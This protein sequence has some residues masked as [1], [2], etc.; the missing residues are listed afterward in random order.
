[1]M[2]SQDGRLWSSP[3]PVFGSGSGGWYPSLAWDPTYHEPAIAFYYCD[4]RVGQ[5]EGTCPTGEDKLVITQRNSSAGNW[6]EE[7][8]DLEGGIQIQLGF[9][10]TGKRWVA[11]RDPRSG[12]VKVATEK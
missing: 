5:N 2:T 11:Y 8:V 6:R 9:F 7:D 4:S 3:D 12:A 1:M 10:T